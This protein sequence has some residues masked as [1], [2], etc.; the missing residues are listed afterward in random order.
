M[1]ILTVM[2]WC[3]VIL[4]C[5]KTLFGFFHN[6]LKKNPKELFCQPSSFAL[7]LILIEHFFICL[8]AL[9]LGGIRG[10]RKGDDRGWDGWMAS[11]TRWTWVWVNS[12]SWWWTG[13]PG[14]LW[15]MR[16]QRVRHNWATEL[17]WTELMLLLSVHKRNWK[18]HKKN[19]LIQGSIS[20]QLFTYNKRSE[21]KET[22]FCFNILLF[23][24]RMFASFLLLVKNLLSEY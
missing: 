16:S 10:R 14:V 18:C 22:Y 8:L 24:M 15:F 11:P 2:R 19:M 23:L 20:M 6:I 9:M 12:G 5:P 13:R 3:L 17:N 4:G 1:A 7:H 21:K